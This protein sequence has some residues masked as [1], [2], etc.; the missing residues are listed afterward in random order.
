MA[1]KKNDLI[2][3]LIM[4]Y[5]YIYIYIYIC[6]SVNLKIKHVNK[7]T[8]IKIT[9]KTTM[10]KTIDFF[11]LKITGIFGGRYIIVCNIY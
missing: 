10:P 6:I 4:V 9:I 3:T 7:T 5:V 2:S 8:A 11:L 1:Q